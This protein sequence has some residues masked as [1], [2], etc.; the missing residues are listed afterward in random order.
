MSRFGN[1][2]NPTHRVADGRILNES[3]SVAV[4]AVL[5]AFDPAD[6]VFHAI[7]SERGPAVDH[8]GKWCLV[9][10]YLD[11]DESLADAVRREVHEEAGIDLKALEAA[12]QARVPSQPVYV[13][14][15][16]GSPR[17]NVTARFS[18][19]LTTRPAPSG[20]NAEP[21]EVADVKWMPVVAS[22]IDALPWAFG[23]DRILRDLADHFEAER[24]RGTLDRSSARRFYRQKIEAGYPFA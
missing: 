15:D 3:R 5:I 21:G 17:Q 12:G 9:C 14:S 18:I 10:G 7:V 24:A 6:G 23:H 13:Q 1:R 16:P 22:A 11:W 2:Q 19:E 20:A 8:T 4:T